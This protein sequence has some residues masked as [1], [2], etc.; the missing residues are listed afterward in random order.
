MI[1][2]IG[3]SMVHALVTH[4]SSPRRHATVVSRSMSAGSALE[5]LK[6]SDTL[7]KHLPRCRWAVPSVLSKSKKGMIGQ[8]FMLPMMSKLFLAVHV[9]AC[10]VDAQKE[11]GTSFGSLFRNVDPL[12]A[13]L[14]SA[15]LQQDSAQAQFTAPWHLDRIDQ[16]N[17][18]LDRTFTPQNYAE[19]VNIYIVSAG[20]NG[21]HIDFR[22]ESGD[23]LSRVKAA[24]TVDPASP[25][26]LDIRGEGTIAAGTAA[27]A[28]HGVAK[29][30]T[31]HSVKVFRDDVLDYTAPRQDVLDGLS[32]IVEHH[33]K[34]AVV[35]WLT[36]SSS[37]IRHDFLKEEVLGNLTQAGLVVVV[38]AGFSPV[39][40]AGAESADACSV[41]VANSARAFTVSS[42]SRNDLLASGS[43]GGRR[44]EART[45]DCV[46]L[47][48]PGTDVLGPSRSPATSELVMVSS[49]VI[50]PAVVAGVAA[51][52]LSVF[53]AAGPDE[54]RKAML[55]ASTPNAIKLSE[56]RLGPL[57][58]SRVVPIGTGQLHARL[59]PLHMELSSSGPR[60]SKQ[61]ISLGLHFPHQVPAQV[62][63]SDIRISLEGLFPTWPSL[64]V[65]ILP[66][67]TR[68]YIISA[69]V[70]DQYHG[71]VT[72]STPFTKTLTFQQ[73]STTVATPLVHQLL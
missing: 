2:H 24:Y 73:V 58:H 67:E 13:P 9:C 44:F 63:T 10:C 26:D 40:T 5:A 36:F 71:K 45:G 62:S 54:V 4:V 56:S 57:A 6:R 69:K 66:A 16:R 17:L 30:A 3:A 14:R 61:T 64:N 8:Q 65:S 12:Y 28:V 37:P 15:S 43:V 32:W 46:A 35:L 29:G 55:D 31:L 48:A 20:I 7:S 50:A 52:Y 33:E 1:R 19:N 11:S 68:G 53:P 39:H 21:A 70:P 60:N 51:T 23:Q 41:T 42:S 18:Q 72:V 49:P 34:P 59:F 27:G 38:P 47:Y 25:A 22:A